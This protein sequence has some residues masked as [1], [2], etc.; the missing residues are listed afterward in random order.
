MAYL[1]TAGARSSGSGGSGGVAGT[2]LQG[3]GNSLAVA[4]YDGHG[5]DQVSR[6]LERVLLQ[7][8]GEEEGAEGRGGG[9]WPLHEGD[10]EETSQRGTFGDGARSLAPEKGSVCEALARPMRG[11][12]IIGYVNPKP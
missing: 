2:V 6:E 9:C 8:R 5:G 12:Y 4:V 1:Y 11:R 10:G 7:V 3:S